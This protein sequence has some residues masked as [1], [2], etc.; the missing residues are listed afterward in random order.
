MLFL[1]HTI[2]ACAQC[3]HIHHTMATPSEKA[4][5]LGLGDKPGHLKLNKKK[6]GASNLLKGLET[7]TQKKSNFLM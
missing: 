3:T 6:V 2:S 7:L 1:N 5:Y 4:G